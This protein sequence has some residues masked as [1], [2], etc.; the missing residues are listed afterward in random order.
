MQRHP[1]SHEATP[2]EGTASVHPNTVRCWYSHPQPEHPPVQQY[3]HPLTHTSAGAPAP[4]SVDHIHLT[5]DF[6]NQSQFQ[7]PTL[8][9]PHQDSSLTY[10]NPSQYPT[11]HTTQLPPSHTP[12]PLPV[13]P[14]EYSISNVHHA[15]HSQPTRRNLNPASPHV[16]SYTGQPQDTHDVPVHGY[17]PSRPT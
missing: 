16:A 5:P 4:N 17:H 11:D 7:L 10:V 12:T 1:P 6:T 14:S 13:P 2:Q 15:M 8:N 3:A 9:Y